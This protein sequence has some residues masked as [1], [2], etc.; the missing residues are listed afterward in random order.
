MTVSHYRVI[1]G[2]DMKRNVEMGETAIQPV[3]AQTA[4]LSIYGL[5]FMSSPC[6]MGCLQPLYQRYMGLFWKLFRPGH[7]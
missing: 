6:I 5:R 2:E 7:V 3:P 4:N 1:Q